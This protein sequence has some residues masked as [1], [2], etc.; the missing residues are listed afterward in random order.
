MAAILNLIRT[1]YILLLPCNARRLDKKKYAFLHTSKR[2]DTNTRVYMSASSSQLGY[3]PEYAGFPIESL[4]NVLVSNGTKSSGDIL[5][6]NGSKWA[7]QAGSSSFGIVSAVTHNTTADTTTSAT[8]VDV[9]G[10]TGTITTTA[11]TSDVV[12]QANFS[13]FAATDDTGVNFRIVLNST[14]GTDNACFIESLVGSGRT[15]LSC[16]ERFTS[17]AAGVHTFKL[18]WLRTVGTGTL[19]RGSNDYMS[20]S[21]TAYP[22]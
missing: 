11:T 8:Y 10:S 19:T 1:S 14:N 17:I 18:Q 7:T 13:L 6:Y 3:K 4:Q 16:C 2:S 12:I 21:A 20:I 5:V 15:G 9:A 22:Q